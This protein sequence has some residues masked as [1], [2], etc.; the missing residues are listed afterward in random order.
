MEFVH[1]QN[2]VHRDLKPVSCASFVSFLL[3]FVDDLHLRGV[4]Q[5]YC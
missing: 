2:V 1:Q 5:T 4:R 3:E